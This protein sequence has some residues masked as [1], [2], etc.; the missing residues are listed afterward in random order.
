METLRKCESCG[1]EFHDTG[2]RPWSWRTKDYQ[3]THW[4]C[5]NGCLTRWNQE[6]KARKEKKHRGWR[7]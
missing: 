4:F 5:S 1:E 6:Q 7:R 3:G 2:N